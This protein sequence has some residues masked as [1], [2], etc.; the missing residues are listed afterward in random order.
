MS[1]LNLIQEV[2]LFPNKGNHAPL[3]YRRSPLPLMLEVI[4]YS[5]TGGVPTFNQVP[6]IQEVTTSS[7]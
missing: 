7:N 6:L 1:S 3:L 5:N 2:T 4:P